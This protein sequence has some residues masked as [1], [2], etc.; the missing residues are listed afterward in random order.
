MES[1][2]KKRFAEGYN[3]KKVFLFFLIGCLIGTYYEE[4]LWFVRHHEWSSRNGLIYGPF[5]PI[6]G[7]G[8]SIFVLF[9]GK[10]N[11][12][13]GILKT[14]LYSCLIGGITEYMTS[15]I[16][17]KVFGIEFWNYSDSFL[18]IGGRTTIPFMIGW[19]LGGTIIMKV[20]YPFLS[21]FIEKIPYQLGTFLYWCIFTVILLDV[22]ITYSAFG[23]MA[24]RNNG[25]K[26]FSIVGKLYDKYYDDEFMY[27]K[28]PVMRPK[29]EKS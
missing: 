2:L 23:R 16:A 8:V 1:G 10:K 29:D 27:Q 24:L 25:Y 6:Y 3:F 11:D 28:F 15:L 7:L 18:N 12:T 22:V 20:F 4:I 13:R 17:D 9:L 14:F 21:K 26:P 19:G 5:S